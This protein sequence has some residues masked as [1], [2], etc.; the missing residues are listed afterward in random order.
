[1]YPP[2]F[3]SPSCDLCGKLKTEKEKV[4]LFVQALNSSSDKEGI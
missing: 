4:V 1:M 3:N 2:L